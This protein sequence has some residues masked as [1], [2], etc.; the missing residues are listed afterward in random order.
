MFAHERNGEA[1][2]DDA[3]LVTASPRAE[4]RAMAAELIAALAHAFPDLL[5]A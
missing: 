3:R 2:T 5:V 4:E 1:L